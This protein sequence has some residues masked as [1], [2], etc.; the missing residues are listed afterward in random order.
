V[1]TGSE[2]NLIRHEV[3]QNAN[4][5]KS[6]RETKGNFISANS[7]AIT[8]TGEIYLEFKIGKQAF[9][10]NF[11]VAKKFCVVSISGY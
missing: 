7:S 9:Q 3:I 4:L 10:E 6:V 8:M 2:I 11:F 5:L 1:D